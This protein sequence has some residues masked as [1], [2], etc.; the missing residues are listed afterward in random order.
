MTALCSASKLTWEQDVIIH[1][2]EGIAEHFF[3]LNKNVLLL[4][5]SREPGEARA[6]TDEMRNNEGEDKKGQN[7]RGNV[8]REHCQDSSSSTDRG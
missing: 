2:D 7:S 1:L 4:H 8:G 6:E 5:F 3:F